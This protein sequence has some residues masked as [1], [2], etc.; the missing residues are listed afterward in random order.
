MKIK[1]SAY[2]AKGSHIENQ[3]FLCATGLCPEQ[4][5]SFWADRKEVEVPFL[6]A[7][8]SDGIG[9]G[10]QRAS[11]S[12]ALPAKHLPRPLRLSPLFLS[13]TFRAAANSMLI[14]LIAVS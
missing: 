4:Q 14:C 7:A 10:G 11:T 9:R 6:Y 2:T 12:R 1:I 3:D 8:V 13:T 5:T